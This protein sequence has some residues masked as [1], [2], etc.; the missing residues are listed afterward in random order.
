MKQRAIL[1]QRGVALIMVIVMIAITSALLMSLTDSTYIS[2]RLNRSAER[3]VQAEYILK[4]AVHFAQVLVKSDTTPNDDPT[5]DAWMQ[6]EQGREVP[7]ALIGIAEPGIR[8]TL[9]ISSEKGKIPLLS[10]LAPNGVD[11]SW[12]D[13]ILALFQNLG[14][15]DDKPEQATSENEPATPP[16]SSAKMVANLIDY[17]DDDKT[18]YSANDGF[19][20]QGYEESLPPGEEL[21]NSRMIESATHELR[22]IPGFTASRVKRLLP[23]ISIR[24]RDKVNINAASAEVLKAII[25]GVDKQADLSYAQKL[26]ECRDPAQQGPYNQSL[27][28]QIT[29]CIND[30]V[31]AQRIAGKLTSQGDTFYVLAKVDYGTGV[32]SVSYIARA[33]LRATAGKG[34]FPTI[35]SML[36]Y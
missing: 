24:T 25:R 28:T 30:P 4:S 11:G 35:E 15:D 27:T 19:Q 23:H 6:F 32:S 9:Q 34:R 17:L 21:P 13:I 22:S 18:N 1:R 36:V 8:I 26:V 2:M 3:R 20:E 31:V 12:R 10:I 33:H 29:Q 14:F 7:G 16:V 5:Q